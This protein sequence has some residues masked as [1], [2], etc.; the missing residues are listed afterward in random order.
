MPRRRLG[1]IVAALLVA[2]GAGHLASCDQA[3][4]RTMEAMGKHK[5]Q[6]LVERVEAARDDQEAAKQQFRDALERFTAVVEFEG[7]DLEARYRALRDD[8]DASEVKAEAVRNRIAAVGEVAQ[9]LFTEWEAELDAY[10]DEDLRLSSEIK[11]Y[12]TRKRYAQLLR[13]MKRAEAKMEPVLAAFRDQVLYLKHNLNARAV[14]SLEQTAAGLKLDVARLIAEMEASI[15]EA[16]A[17]IEAMGLGPAQ[18]D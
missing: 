13:S 8:L 10:T 4:Y 9:A 17:F 14:A 3:Y 18:G 11:M 5:R 6:L 7:G 16:D 12:D 15:A 2:V 1:A